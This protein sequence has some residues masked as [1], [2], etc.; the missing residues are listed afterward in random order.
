M[1]YMPASNARALEKARTLAADALIFDLEDAVAPDAKLAARDA[2]V[3]AAQSKRYGA[4]EVLIRVNAL[5]T[6]WALGDIAAAAL[7]Q[8]DG[9]VLPK[10]NGPEDIARF[11][12]LLAGSGAPSTMMMWVMMETP[13]AILAAAQIAA[14]SPRL[15]GFLVGSADLAKDLRAGHPRDRAT[16]LTSLQLCVLAARAYGRAVVDGVFFEID[17]ASGFEASCRQGRALGFNGKT[18]IHPN[19]IAVANEVYAPS[20][21]ELDHARRVI[22]AH[23]AA[24]RAGKGITVLDGRLV[25]V[26]HVREAERLLAQAEAIEALAAGAK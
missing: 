20:P 12:A 21:A 14:A 4:R 3:A 8:A 24:S 5:D 25:E 10:V 6:T 18:L 11:D 16:M 13:R 26:L 1:L 7:S 15:A 23:A 17:D 9:V 2:A 19:Q 22:A